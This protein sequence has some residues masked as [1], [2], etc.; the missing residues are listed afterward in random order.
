[1]KI[2]ISIIEI[3]IL[4]IKPHISVEQYVHRF[5]TNRCKI[6]LNTTIFVTVNDISNS[7]FLLYM[8]ELTIYIGDIPK[9]LGIEFWQ[10]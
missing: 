1:M 7:H 6:H 5:H 10:F 9:D 2:H 8:K 4:I 3:H